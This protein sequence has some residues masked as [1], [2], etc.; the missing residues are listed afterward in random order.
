MSAVGPLDAARTT[1]PPVAVDGE[2]YQQLRDLL[3]AGGVVALT[4]AGMSTASGIPDYRGPDG[5]RRVQPMQHGEFVG[6]AAARRRYWAR[7]YVGWTRF[8][9]ARPNPAHHAVADLERSGLL[10]HVITQN[11]DGLHQEAGS[12]RVLELHGSLAAVEC[13]DCGEATTREQVQEWLS[14]ANPDFLARVDAPSQVR[15]DGD[16]ALPE[17]LVAGFRAPRCLVCGS[18]RLKPDV[19]FF[20]GSVAKDLV[21]RAFAFVDEARTLLVLGSSLRVMSGYRFVRRAARTGIPVAV[22]TRAGTRGDA[23]A[24][25]RLDALLGDVLPALVADL[26]G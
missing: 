22:V 25:V 24:T 6:S 16:V 12:R 4:G 3:G 9:A 8:A 1:P 20:G 19:V 11:V 2:A 7:A 15:P 5:T 18:D 10:R 23:E 26:G 17:E 21:E 14:V 13:L